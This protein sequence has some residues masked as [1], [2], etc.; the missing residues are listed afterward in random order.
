MSLAAAGEERSGECGERGHRLWMEGKHKGKRQV[1]DTWSQKSRRGRLKREC[2]RERERKSWFFELLERLEHS[3]MPNGKRGANCRAAMRPERESCFVRLVAWYFNGWLL[4]RAVAAAKSRRR[5]E[6]QQESAGRQA[7][8][9]SMVSKVNAN[10]AISIWPRCTTST[11]QP[12]HQW[13]SALQISLFD[14]AFHSFFWFL[15]P[16]C[17]CSQFKNVVRTFYVTSGKWHRCATHTHTHTRTDI[18]VLAKKGTRAVNRTWH[19]F[20][21]GPVLGHGIYVHLPEMN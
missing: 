19:E 2:E 10:A 21:F 15:W 14:L 18:C 1:L 16:R 3:Q 4:N 13:Q 6:Q 8:N 9:V 11:K 7:G 20:M 5:Q 17:H 12:W